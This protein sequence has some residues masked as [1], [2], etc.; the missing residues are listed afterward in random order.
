MSIAFQEEAERQREEKRRAKLQELWKANNYQSNRVTDSD[1]EG[2]SEDVEEIADEQ[3]KIH[4]VFGDVMK[5]EFHGEKSII[6]VHC[7]GKTKKSL[8]FI[9]K[10]NEF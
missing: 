9:D 7:V 4:Y 8:C 3:T 6:S 10:L 2:E 5:P 1:D